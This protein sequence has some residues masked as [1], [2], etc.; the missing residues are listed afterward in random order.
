MTDIRVPPPA[1]ASTPISESVDIYVGE[2]WRT[3]FELVVNAISDLEE[4]VEVIEDH[5]HNTEKWFGIHPSPTTTVWGSVNSLAPYTVT[6]GNNAYGTGATDAAQVIGSA[7]TPVDTGNRYYDLHRLFVASSS[8]STVWKLRIIY[9]TG[10]MAAA[11]SAGKF[12][13]A[14][15]R[16]DS[17]NPA[18]SDGSPFDIVMPR[19]AVGTQV[20]IQGWNATDDAT[21]TLYAGVHEYDS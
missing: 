1:P 20:W 16:I 15:V 17:T 2:I 8:V 3:W 5:F 19:V 14:I 13:T 4:E 18:Q 11:L 12:S 9:G 7:D 21:I 10:T 6:S